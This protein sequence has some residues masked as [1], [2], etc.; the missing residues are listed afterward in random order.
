MK[1][2][3]TFPTGHVL[4]LAIAVSVSAFGPQFIG[5]IKVS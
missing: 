1:A 2:L 4:A 5:A 3:K